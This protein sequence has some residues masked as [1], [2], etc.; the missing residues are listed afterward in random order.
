M[1]DLDKPFE[2]EFDAKDV[3]NR[4]RSSFTSEE[5]EELSLEG[6]KFIS[7]EEM[8]DI[9]PQGDKFSLRQIEDEDEFFGLIKKED[10]A[11]GMA[12]VEIITSEQD[13]NQDLQ[14]PDEDLNE[15]ALEID[16]DL[17]EPKAS[18]LDLIHKKEENLTP[19]EQNEAYLQRHFRDFLS[20]PKISG[21]ITKAIEKNLI[22]KNIVLKTGKTIEIADDMPH[23]TEITHQTSIIINRDEAGELESMEVIC[24]CGERT[25]VKF[26]Y[27]SANDLD[28]D[29]TEV[30]DNPFDPI[31]FDKLEKKNDIPTILSQE[32]LNIPTEEEE[33]AQKISEKKNKKGYNPSEDDIDEEDVDE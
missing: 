17:E 10:I 2:E 4:P 27:I 8:A 23:T 32:F 7:G 11:S 28:E 5:E 14:I 22:P 13:Y 29:L 24:K 6:K 15:P 16:D 21:N 19:E 31:S 20:I 12:K 1:D 25:L 33:A 18:L 9:I 30:E 26:D 3:V